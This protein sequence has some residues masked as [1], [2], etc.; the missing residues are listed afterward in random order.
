MTDLD[1]LEAVC[2]DDLSDYKSFQKGIVRM[3]TL[4]DR[5]QTFETYAV[6]K[7]NEFA[8]TACHEI[9]EKLGGLFNPLFIYGN[10]GTG[11]THLLN[12][13]GISIQERFP[14]KIILLMTADQL[15]K[16]IVDSIRND[17][18]QTFRERMDIIDVL[19]V[20]DIQ[21]ISG[22][23]ATQEEF[24]HIFNQM[25][26]EKK[27]IIISS[28]LSPDQMPEFE[29]RLQSRFMRGVIA[30]IAPLT[31]ELKIEIMKR[32][33]ESNEISLNEA[34]I[35]VIAQGSY[36]NIFELEGAIKKMVLYAYVN[37]IAPAEITED[38][39]KEILCDEDNNR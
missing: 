37:H 32:Y 39:V 7:S 2:L 4:F 33:I 9:I 24:F 22:K 30:E 16:D 28:N 18:V 38:Q 26:D 1:I 14:N 13:T 21:S 25:Y 17:A 35:E 5:N 20:D 31:K 11:K 19:I 3:L 15:T 10:T 8:V 23:T 12:A 27:Q 6:G 29:E 36:A 34:L